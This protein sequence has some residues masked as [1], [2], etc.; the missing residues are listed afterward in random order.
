ITTNRDL[1][2]GNLV[3]GSLGSLPLLLR[4]TNRLGPPP[5]ASAPS[6]PFTGAITN[7]A[8]VF[9]PNTK[10]PYSQ[11]WSFGIQRE[12]M[13][14]TALEVRYVGTRFLRGWTTYNLNSTENNIL[15]NGLLDEFKLAQ[16]NLRANIA[17]GRGN[18]FAYTGAPGTSPLPIT[19]AYFSGTPKAQAND[20]A[21]YTSTNFTSATFVNTLALNNPNV[22]CG[23]TS[24]SGALDNNA[25]FRA[26]AL[27]A[28]LPAN[29][30][31]TNPGLRGGANFTGNGGYTRYDAFQI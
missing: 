27:R 20:S 23:T 13:K 10:V 31:L 25:T 7:S 22:C 2:T 28:G 12:V 3:G 9:D 1:A 17:A 5:F 30:M 14:D 19:L 26:N 16:A 4:E 18:T 8:N 24:Y 11:S 6:Y 15:E 29:F 21:L